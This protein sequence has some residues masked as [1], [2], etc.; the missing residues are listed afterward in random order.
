VP[1]VRTKPREARAG[2]NLSAANEHAS[3]GRADGSHPLGGERRRSGCARADRESGQWKSESRQ[4]AKLPGA[5]SGPTTATCRLE[6]HGL[7]EFAYQNLGVG[8]GRAFPVTLVGAPRIA[9]IHLPPHTMKLRRLPTHTMKLRRL[10][11]IA[12]FAAAAQTLACGKKGNEVGLAPAAVSLAPSTSEA[13]TGTWRY[14]IGPSGSVHVEL[15][16]LKEHIIGD[17]TTVAGVVDIVPTDLA[18]SRGQVRVDLSTFSTTTFGNDKD[19]AQTKHARTWLEVQV[20][21]QTNEAMRYAEFAIRSIDALSATDITQVAPIRDGQN[22]VRAVSMT[23]HGDL[24]VHGHRVPKDDVIDVVFY[25]PVGAA[26]DSKPARLEITS[27]TPM[28]VVLKEHDVRPRDPAGQLL[29]WTTSLISKV[30]ETADVTL[31]LG[32][33][34]AT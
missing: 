18:Q 34:P 21:D 7:F 26:A 16:G 3:R 12:G 15:P 20:G 30:A 29:S 32:A 2:V 33:L 5:M 9:D 24:L 28:R 19:A 1:I 22:D 6:Q 8:G 17:A 25:Y 27:K 13:G 14:A 31:R 23:V 11:T 10:A 4:A